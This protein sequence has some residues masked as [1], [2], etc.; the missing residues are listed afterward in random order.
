MEEN[1]K[2][3]QTPEFDE[4]ELRGKKGWQKKLE[5]KD[6]EIRSLNA[7]VDHWK[8]EYY[9]AYADTQ[10][11]RKALEKDH[12]EAIRYRASG[13]VEDLLPILDSF[14]MALSST[15]DNPEIKNYLLG[16][17][18][19]YNNLINALEN[20][21]V[22]EISPKENDKFDIETMEAVES[23][24]DEGEPYRILKV[25]AKGYKLHDRLIRPARVTVSKKVENKE[26][27]KTE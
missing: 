24:E 13:F 15:P 22:S 10:N 12:Q 1:K 25:H 7:Q 23:V 27:E 6:E 11:L 2:N 19:I 14:H 26:S 3:N 21:G 17:T 16:F 20:E 18:Y 4:D 8:N 9:R 5:K